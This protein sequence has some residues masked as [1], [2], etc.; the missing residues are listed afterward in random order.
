MKKTMSMFD[1]QYVSDRNKHLAVPSQ[2]YE[3]KLN[4]TFFN[5]SKESDLDSLFAATSVA[6]SHEDIT[7]V[8]NLS[9][10]SKSLG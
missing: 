6:F 10:V 9:C 5:N 3:I 8:L 1:Y 7:I 4:F 2:P